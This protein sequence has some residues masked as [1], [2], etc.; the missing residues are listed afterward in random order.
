[1]NVMNGP[2]YLLWV[3]LDVEAPTSEEFHRLAMEWLDGGSRTLLPA[4]RDLLDSDPDAMWR[5]PDDPE[6]PL[7]PPGAGWGFLMVDNDLPSGSFRI[8]SKPANGKGW[9]WVS[10]QVLK[11]AASAKVKIAVLDAAGHGYDDMVSLEVARHKESPGWI[12]L[13]APVPAS[14]FTDPDQGL[15]QQER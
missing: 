1:M 4:A 13:Q 11:G 9:R 6:L 3:E 7:G 14:D 8:S 2:W 12:R 5:E 15:V 10:G